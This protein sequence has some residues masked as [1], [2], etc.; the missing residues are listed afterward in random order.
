METTMNMSSYHTTQD[1]DMMDVFYDVCKNARIYNNQVWKDQ[2]E[3]T[4]H[5]LME[6]VR[7]RREIRSKILTGRGI[8]LDK[9][10]R[11]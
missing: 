5:Q 7:E 10:K 9:F 1:V 3:W 2:E 8:Q 4:N 6:K 11:T